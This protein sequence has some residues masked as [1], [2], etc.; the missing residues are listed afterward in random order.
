MK[1]KSRQA[2]E[3]KADVLVAGAGL[4]GRILS[5]CLTH[6]TDGD[7]AVSLVDGA[8]GPGGHNDIRA[9]ALTPG[10][11]RMLETLGVWE[12]LDGQ[13]EPSHAMRITDSALDD[14]IR[15]ALLHFGDEAAGEPIAHFVEARHLVAATEAACDAAGLAPR[16]GQR[17]RGVELQGQHVAATGVPDRA[18]LLV[19]AD[20]ARS[21]VRRGAGIGA[22]GWPYR[23]SA[24]VALLDTEVPHDGEAVQH[25]LPDGPFALLP[26][27]DGRRG[28]VWT[29]PT[30][31]AD[32]LMR[33]PREELRETIERGAGPEFGAVEIAEGPFS[34]PLS[35]ML[36][37]RYVGDRV[38]LV[39]DAAHRLHPLA[40]LGLNVGF[41]DAAALAEVIVEA[42]RRGEDIGSLGVL[43]RYEHWR[44]PDAVALAAVT[45]GLNRLFGT[46]WG[47]LRTLRDAG[48]SLV[49][50]SHRLKTQ[51]T[52]DADGQV[53]SAPRLFQ[54][55][56]I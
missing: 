44:R 19:G 35:L 43:E 1:A 20:G 30:R 45:E 7:M 12:R 52:R 25:F 34:F 48:L 3:G 14:V 28:L 24:I 55:L 39:G 31:R 36:A 23:Q 18:R 11:Q 33:L 10:A 50:R 53:V 2:P 56:P 41:R 49:E 16:F 8:P 29:L 40:G 22:V 5:L 26:L 9:Y 13:V 54:G 15:P 27:P 37:R 4:V 42:A 47:P 32:E 51:L 21:A 17:I 38:A 6:A 46:S